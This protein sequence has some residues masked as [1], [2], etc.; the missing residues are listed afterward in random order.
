MGKANERSPLEVTDKA[1]DF[2]GFKALRDLLRWIDRAQQR[3]PP[4][5]TRDL[6]TGIEA[7]GAQALRVRR[8]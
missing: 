4:H 6:S 7:S 1:L 5:D 2:L 8:R 3:G